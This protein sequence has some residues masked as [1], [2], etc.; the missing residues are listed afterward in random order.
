ML[1]QQHLKAFLDEKVD[2]Y[3]QVSFIHT[4]PI[5]VPHQYS[6][7]QD[8]EISGLFSAV[9]AWGLRKTAIR[10]TLDLLESMDNAPYDFI[11]NHK[12]SDLRK[13]EN[14]KHRTFNG[15]DALYFIYFLHWYYN[16]YNSLEEIFIVDSDDNS[17]EAGLI[18]FH[19]TFFSL[20]EV[21]ARTRKH[22]STPLNRSTCKRLNMYL[23]WMV[24]KDNRKVD[25]GIW[26]KILMK[27]LIC[28]IDLHVD[29]IARKLGLIS[30][31]QTDWL[32]AVELT[33]NLRLMDPED[34]VKYDY[35]LFGIGILEKRLFP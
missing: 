25:F 29:R 27:D 17:I 3:N 20:D 35:A 8:I 22:I 5:L 9:F 30:R 1:K 15:T 10:K 14:F 31:K 23:R 19:N 16:N 33:R 13:I 7:K 26:N 34:P 12:S 28:P 32:T 18:Q 21:P 6:T 11:K 2:H 24:R 4:D